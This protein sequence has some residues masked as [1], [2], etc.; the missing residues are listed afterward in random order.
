MNEAWF[1]VSAVLILFSLPLLYRAF[2]APVGIDCDERV[3]TERQTNSAYV[4]VSLVLL[5]PVFLFWWV[6][7]TRGI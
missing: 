7:L 1:P 4:F 2:M 6:V 3:P 5:T